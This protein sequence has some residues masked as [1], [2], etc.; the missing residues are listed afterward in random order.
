M[1]HSNMVV[2]QTVSSIVYERIREFVLTGRFLPG[3]WLREKELIE[4]LGVSRTPIREAFRRLEQEQLV[5]SVPRYGFRVRTFSKEEIRDFFELR[6]ELEGMAA[7]LAAERATVN[8][9]REISE[10]L[11]Q[12]RLS[13]DEGD[14]ADVIRANNL[15]HDRVAESSG[16]QALVRCLK[17]LRAGVNLQ[18]VLTWSKHKDRPSATLGQHF[19]IYRAIKDGD[20]RLARTTASKHVLDSLE[21]ALE[22]IVFSEHSTNPD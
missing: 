20:S 15:F 19:E 13:L 1:K 14:S 16:N 8:S 12:A 3:Q 5:E 4:I 9:V 18:R 22:T 11:T 2:A 6:A 7:G 21:L 10:S 17:Q